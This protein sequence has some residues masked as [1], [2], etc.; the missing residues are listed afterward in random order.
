MKKIYLIL[1]LLTVISNVTVNA[2]ENDD[3]NIDSSN[4]DIIKNTHLSGFLDPC[5]KLTMESEE[6]LK[7]LLEENGFADFDKITR[8]SERLANQRIS[9]YDIVDEIKMAEIRFYLYE[10]P[11]PY[12][13]DTVIKELTDAQRSDLIKTLLTN[14]PETIA[15]IRENIRQ[16]IDLQRDLMRAFLHENNDIE[17]ENHD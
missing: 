15:C 12:E 2:M 6:E 7:Q 11:H 17:N 8:L 13:K 5:P 4:I 1:L 9:P 3:N 14:H 10:N 16:G